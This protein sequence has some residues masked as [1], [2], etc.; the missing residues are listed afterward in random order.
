MFAPYRCHVVCTTGQLASADAKATVVSASCMCDSKLDTRIVR[1]GY[2]FHF[3]RSFAPSSSR[4][5]RSWRVS[6]LRQ[7]A[8]HLGV[9]RA[10]DRDAAEAAAVAAFDLDPDQRKRLAVRE[11]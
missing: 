5:L 11:N 8:Y 9:V 4:R 10:P 3:A 7:R 6:I 2:C 1:G